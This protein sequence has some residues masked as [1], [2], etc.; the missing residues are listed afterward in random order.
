MVNISKKRWIHPE[1]VGYIQ[2]FW[3]LPTFFRYI[4]LFFNDYIKKELELF[5]DYIQL[6]STF[7]LKK[8]EVSKN[9]GY[10]QY[11]LVTSDFSG[12]F[13]FFKGIYPTVFEST[14]LFRIFPSFL[15]V[16]NIFW[17]YPT[18]TNYPVL[19]GFL[20]K[21]MEVF[22]YIHRNVRYILEKLETSKKVE[23]I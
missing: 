22:E 8:I 2:L 17:I 12:F 18:T 15:D 10:M 19:F 13:Q 1:N 23:R 4:H 7:T 5:F 6:F 9:F 16:S 11:L 21:K 3:V 20:Y 14:Q